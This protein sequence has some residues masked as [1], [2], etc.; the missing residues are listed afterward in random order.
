MH[1]T[2]DKDQPT[3]TPESLGAVAEEYK[4]H[5]VY[6]SAFKLIGSL[7]PALVM[8]FSLAWQTDSNREA[9]VCSGVTFKAYQSR[10]V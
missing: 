6:V 4:E 2:M 5:E 3:S 1:S 9:N 8:P 7:N 10:L